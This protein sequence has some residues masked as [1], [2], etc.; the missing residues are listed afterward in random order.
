MKKTD[1]TQSWR[2]G[3]TGEQLAPVSI[4]HDAMLME[5]RKPENPSG[6]GAAYFGGGSYEYVKEFTL[7]ECS[8]AV[9]L[10]EGIYPTGEIF[11]DGEKAA[12]AHYGYGDCF[13]D[14]SRLADGKPHTVHVAVDNTKTPNSR[15]Y[16]GAGI[17]RPV[18]L[19]TG[20]EDHILPEGIRVSTLS[21]APAVIRVQTAHVGGSVSISILDGEQVIACADGDDVTIEI[22]NAKLWDDEHPNLYTCRASLEGDS[23]EVRFG[24]R[25]LQWNLE[26]FFV[27]GKSVKFRGGC[28]HHDNGILGA[29]S[30]YAS[31]YRRMTKL[32]SLGFNAI[33]SAHHP[34]CRSLLDACDELGLYVMDETWDMWYSSKTEHDYSARF[35]ANW[36]QDVQA[37]VA[38]DFSHP[39]VVMYSIGN[40]VTE[41]VEDRGVELTHE[42]VEMFH[43]L[44]PSRPTTAGINPALLM[45]RKMK[46]RMDGQVEPEKEE[47]EA[48]VTST[49]F[50]KMVSEMGKRMTEGASRPEVDE[51][52]SPC[53]N[54]LDIAGYN[55][56]TSCYTVDA[57]RHPGRLMV[58]SETFPQ[59]LPTNWALVQKLPYLYGD[60]MWTA[61]D[62]LGEVGL[63]SWYYGQ[64]DTSFGKPYPWLLADSGAVDVLGNENAE[65]GLASVVWGA[66]KTPYISTRP[67]NQDADQLYIAIWRGTNALPS[68]SWRD[69]EGRMAD[70]EVYSDAAEIELLLNGVSLGRTA[71]GSDFCARFSVP[72]APGTLAAIAYDAAGERVSESSLV[73]ASGKLSIRAQQEQPAVSGQPVYVNIDIV[74]ENGIVE[75]NADR[76]LT[77]RTEGAQLLGF[78]SANPKTEERFESGTYTTYYGRSQ[79]ILLP[80]SSKITL[81]VT[82][83]GMEPVEVEI[84]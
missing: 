44:D 54:A 39:S 69:C 75:C 53:M 9:L 65:A 3:R 21:Y 84:Q 49:E 83:E 50:N 60:F 47:K 74:G 36:Q 6:S 2:F 72:Y 16:S 43:Q 17:Y 24:I 52:S 45:M 31:E 64:D 33:R 34:M 76:T 62:Y 55:Y 41:P 48:N 82:A 5:Q 59:D 40:E 80:Q 26:G 42:L 71:V 70:V 57:G 66:R 46:L 79:A 78:G 25:T 7:P 18:W 38:K 14:C 19:F 22:P 29:R 35:E 51:A 67:V 81:T 68:W 28:I 4:P 37:L 77:V 11:L 1:F 8:R 63:G 20:T 73:S 30:Y 58:G 13:V 10:F 23:A 12:F 27:N 56:A 15:W 61:W 32:K